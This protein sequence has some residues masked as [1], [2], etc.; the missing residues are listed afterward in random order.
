MNASVIEKSAKIQSVTIPRS[1]TV[2]FDATIPSAHP[3]ALPHERQRIALSRQTIAWDALDAANQVKME[4]E[5]EYREDN[6]KPNWKAVN[7]VTP[8]WDS[9]QNANMEAPNA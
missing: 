2:S 4:V 8:R 7:G 6:R 9:L 5:R 3:A 1:Y